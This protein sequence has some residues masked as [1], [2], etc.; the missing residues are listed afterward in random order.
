MVKVVF[1]GDRPS[2]TNVSNYIAFVGAKC[3]PRFIE[4]I[5]DLAPDY[6]TCYNVHDSDGHTDL[7]NVVNIMNL[8]E[9]GFKVIALGKQA[10]AALLTQ[11]IPHYEIPHPSG[12]NRKINDQYTI[13]QCLDLAKYYIRN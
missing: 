3:F 1:V 6:Y 4:W 13:D 12:R 2:P 11:G 9:S 5:K 7:Q 8:L 10:S